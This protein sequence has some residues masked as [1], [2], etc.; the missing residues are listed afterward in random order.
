MKNFDEISRGVKIE[1]EDNEIHR[2]LP[3][4]GCVSIG[5]GTD[6]KIPY[7]APRARLFYLS[8]ILARRGCADRGRDT[9]S[10]KPR[11]DS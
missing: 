1:S 2:E 9:G 3:R 11:Y 7:I 4:V 6:W 10:Q 8:N 5:A